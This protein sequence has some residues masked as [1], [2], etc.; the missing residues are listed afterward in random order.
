MKLVEAV[1]LGSLVVKPKAGQYLIADE[2]CVIG[3][4]MKAMS[5]NR[6]YSFPKDI[7]NLLC[8]FPFLQKLVKLPCNCTAQDFGN[9]IAQDFDFLNCITHIFDHH[10][11]LPKFKDCWTFDQL[12]DWIEKTENSLCEEEQQTEMQHTEMTLV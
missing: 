11:A 12:C 5:V 1:R 3:M 8:K 4:A 9:Y 7:I 10:V 2:G 6:V